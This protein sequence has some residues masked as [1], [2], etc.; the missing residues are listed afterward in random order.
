MDLVYSVGLDVKAEDV[1]GAACSQKCLFSLVFGKDLLDLVLETSWLNNFILHFSD[2][3]NFFCLDSDLGSQALKVSV[4]LQHVFVVNFEVVEC[5]LEKKED[6][7]GVSDRWIAEFAD[8][9]IELKILKVL[10]EFLE[11]FLLHS[12]RVQKERFVS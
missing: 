9:D 2:L 3:K 11:C 10:F 4:Q 8:I 6:T 7:D 12:W 5:N 1:L